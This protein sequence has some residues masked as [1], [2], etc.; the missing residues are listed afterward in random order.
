MNSRELVFR[1]MKCEEVDRIPWVPFVGCHAASLIDV[2]CEEF[3]K[4]ADHIV[5][6]VL[7]AVELY[8][9]DGIPA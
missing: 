6:G 7:K 9:P 3:F 1:A 2:N 5:N 8:Q 4:S